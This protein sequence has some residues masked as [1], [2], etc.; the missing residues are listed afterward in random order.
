M[1]T[2]G[3]NR[4]FYLVAGARDNCLTFFLFGWASCVQPNLLLAALRGGV[5]PV[6][7]S[8]GPLDPAFRRARLKVMGVTRS[9]V[10]I[11]PPAAGN[12]KTFG[13]T[14]G[15]CWLRGQDLNLRP[16]GYE[17]YELPDCSTPRWGGRSL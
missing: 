8:Q 11:L 5:R 6:R 7:G 10:Q 17:P 2:S 12:K 13:V 15:F 3:I 14:E 16:Q 9:Q 1:K 4:I